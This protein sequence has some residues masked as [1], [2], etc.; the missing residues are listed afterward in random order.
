MEITVTIPD[1]VAAQAE[2][3]GLTPEDYIEK[4]IADQVAASKPQLS[5]AERLAN[6]ERF[7]KDISANSE[8]I[9]LL[10]DAAFTRESFYRDH[11]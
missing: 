5:T 1:E 3:R 2:L 4:L 9:P 7:I 8:N 10:P 11:D 6:L